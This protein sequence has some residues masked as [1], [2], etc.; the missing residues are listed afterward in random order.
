MEE[1]LHHVHANSFPGAGVGVSNAGISNVARGEQPAGPF[2]IDHAPAVNGFGQMPPQQQRQ[3]SPLRLPQQVQQVPPY[4]SEEL[5]I[6]QYI[7]SADNGAGSKWLPGGVNANT[8]SHG[9]GGAGHHGEFA[10]S[11]H[12][13]RN[14]F[15][16]TALNN[17]HM[18]NDPSVQESLSP[19]FQPFGIDV[20]HLPLTNPPI[21][22]GS[23]S[24]IDEPVRRRRIS[25][26]NGQINQLSE[27]LETLENL[28][29]TQPPPLPHRFDS[30][31][32]HSS[33]LQPQQAKP[34]LYD[35]DASAQPV[36][37][38]VHAQVQAEVQAQAQVEAH[39]RASSSTNATTLKDSSMPPQGEGTNSRVSPGHWN[40]RNPAK[41]EEFSD[42]QLV[43]PTSVPLKGSSSGSSVSSHSNRTSEP[44]PGTN[45]WKRAR[46][47]ERN[48]MAAS[49]CRQRKKVAQLQL[50]KDFDVISKDNKIMRRKLDYYEKLV[51]KFKR[52]S[53]A[54][55]RKCTGS[56]ESLEIIEEMLMIDS[57]VQEV[58][59]SGLVVKLEEN[60]S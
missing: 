4:Y 32:A 5:V 10:G 41:S 55:L 42:E 1:E 13:S 12:H 34:Q 51:A 24:S 17:S 11:F 21:F 3:Q 7:P 56:D 2:A 54:H 8:G 46:L 57:G 18:I 50:Q 59:D 44:I 14:G 39:S 60:W 53:E 30:H 26:S 20:N 19:F 9:G 25:I 33:Q 35:P 29:N 38:Q 28:Y 16:G 27:D 45:A 6:P 23:V 48:R 15:N 43:D 37:A 49:K 52:F 31:H 58:N 40:N 36:H 22:Q 47:L